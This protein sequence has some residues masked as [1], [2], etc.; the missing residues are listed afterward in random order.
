MRLLF[1]CP[2]LPY[3]PRKGAALRTWAFVRHLARRHEVSLL[4]FADAAAAAELRDVC[5]RIVTVPMPRRSLARRLATVGGSPK[6]DMFWRLRSPRFGRALDAWLGS[7][8]FDAVIFE[9]LEMAPY[10]RRLPGSPPAVLDEL[11]AEYVLQRRAALN[12]LRSPGRWVGGAYSLLQWL[13]LRRWEAATLRRFDRVVAVSEDDARALRAI[14]RIE[15]AVV[16]NGVEI[17]AFAEVFRARQACETYPPGLLFVG[18]LDFRPNVDALVW[19]VREI[20]PRLHAA[21]PDLRFRIVGAS[22][23][24]TVRRLG[25]VAGVEV[26]GP[27]ED[28]RP[29]LAEAAVYVLPMRIGGGIRLKLLEAM[30]AGVPVVTTAMGAEGVPVTEQHVALA[31]TPPAFADTALRLLADPGLARSQ[32]SHAHALAAARYDWAGIA[33]GLEGVL[34]GLTC[35]RLRSR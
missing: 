6:P 8:A 31:D 14:A 12:D 28:V 34:E 20:W 26:V 18:T 27:V 2:G 3:P 32:A 10:H 4:S 33:A 23:S 13:E 11:N 17:A 16:P 22:P 7:A 9:S 29:F 35:C 24:S 21:R 19:F 1:V 5:R 30:A 25:E 15:P